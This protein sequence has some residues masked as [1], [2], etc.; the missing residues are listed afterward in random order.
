[1][2]ADSRL[3]AHAHVHA[4]EFH[5]ELVILDF[6]GGRYFS[7]DEVGTRIWRGLVEGAT[8][9]EIAAALTSEFDVD[10]ARAFAD[11]TSLVD[12]LLAK[13]LLAASAESE[14]SR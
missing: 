12:E 8:P 7:L 3:H 2:I 9:R 6:S 11:V 5:G 1:M 13:G 10:E 14:P 4:R